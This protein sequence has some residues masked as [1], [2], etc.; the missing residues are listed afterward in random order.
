MF[1]FRFGYFNGDIPHDHN[2][3]LCSTIFIS[4]ILVGFFI[5]LGVAT[6]R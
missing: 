1:T 2:C 3:D 4:G 5:G 6:I